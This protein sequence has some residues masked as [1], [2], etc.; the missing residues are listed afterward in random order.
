[1]T[2]AV[3][4]VVTLVVASFAIFA[5]VYLAP[6]DPTTL[7]LGNAP[8]TPAALATIHRELHLNQP[9]L[10]RYWDWLSAALHGNFGTSFVYN[11]SV[12]RLLVPRAEHSLELIAYSGV[13]IVIC[14]LALGVAGAVKE[15]TLGHVVTVVSSV[16][17]GVPAF[18]AAII[19]ASLF[20]VTF[21]IFPVFGDGTG[22]GG[23]IWHLT[24]PA[25]ALALSWIGYVG[26]VTR[27][28]VRTELG[29]DHVLAAR[30]RGI[31]ERFVI[32][33]H[34]LRNAGG[35]I[36]TV[37]GLALAGMLAGAVAVET[38]FGLSGL[39]AFLV[40]AATKKDFAVVQASVLLLVVLFVLVNTVVDALNRVLDPRLKLRS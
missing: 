15:R 11:T 36:A 22:V 6:G 40:D 9:F 1:V 21:R 5:A 34:V 28:A 31:P 10:L 23:T 33:R 26:Q 4:L 13:L 29:A 37:A 19:L 2:K 16:F 8:P 7:L 39:G 20:A 35:P 18:V 25:I 30:A 3:G 14:G 24:L 17:I 38:A 32:R 12:G 27:A